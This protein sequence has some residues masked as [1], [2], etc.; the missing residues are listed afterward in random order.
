M[1]GVA[2][3]ADMLATTIAPMADAGTPWLSASASAF[4]AASMARVTALSSALQKRR[5][6]MPVRG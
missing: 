6:W 2:R 3:S 4:P 1:L 5:A